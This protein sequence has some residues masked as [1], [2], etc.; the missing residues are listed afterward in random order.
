[1]TARRFDELFLAES[2]HLDGNHLAPGDPLAPGDSPTVTA[3]DTGEPRV[4]RITAPRLG[5]ALSGG[6]IR[7]ATFGLG[8]LQGLDELGLLHSVDYSPSKRSFLSAFLG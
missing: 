5:L 8:L 2:S 1:M 4:T 6:G 3:P 7:S